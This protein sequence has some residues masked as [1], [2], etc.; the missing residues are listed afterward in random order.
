[1]EFAKISF[2]SSWCCSNFIAASLYC[3]TNFNPPYPPSNIASQPPFWPLAPTFGAWAVECNH[4]TPCHWGRWRCCCLLF[5]AFAW[6]DANAV[7]ADADGLEARE[8]ATASSW[9]LLA[10]WAIF[11][12]NP[13]KIAEHVVVLRQWNSW[14]RQWFH[15]WLTHGKIMLIVLCCCHLGGD[16]LCCYWGLHTLVY[17]WLRAIM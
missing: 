2:T 15:W 12:L 17:W 7:D 1:M 3:T 8:V 11:I 14:R 5:V 13:T 4:V 16:R 6:A 9:E 10:N